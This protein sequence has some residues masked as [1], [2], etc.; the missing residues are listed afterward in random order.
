MTTTLEP[1]PVVVALPKRRPLRSPPR[2]LVRLVASAAAVLA[3]TIGVV[4]VQSGSDQAPVASAAVALNTAASNIT[5]TD[6]PLGPGQYRYIA[7]HT[8]NLYAVNIE[9]RSGTLYEHRAETWVPHDQ[10]QEWL[11]RDTRIGLV[12]YEDPEA[13]ASAGLWPDY[14]PTFDP[15]HQARCGDYMAASE[16]REPCTHEVSW[17]RPT[18]E[19]LDDLPREPSALLELLRASGHKPASENAVEAATWVL[20]SGLVPADLRAAL[21]RALALVPELE[22]TDEFANLDG[23]VGMALGITGLAERQDLIVDTATGQFIGERVVATEGNWPQEG[24]IFSYSAVTT[25]VVDE[26]GVPPA[27]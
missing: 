25:A 4:G 6:P 26:I 17:D 23:R 15:E 19:F 1:E 7:L 3:L 22:I 24:T 9:D 13:A 16:N 10:N 8:W 14:L 18:R 21:Y 27:G 11:R 5:A 20:R 2:R 12:D